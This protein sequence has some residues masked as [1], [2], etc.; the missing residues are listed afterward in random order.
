[1]AD[2]S[3]SAPRNGVV[4]PQNKQTYAELHQIADHFIGGNRVENAKDSKVKDFVIAN[5]GH[6][7]ITNVLI[8]NNGIA[9][10]KEI[11]SVRKW[12]YETFG[13]E[14]AI[15]FTV[16]AT[17][18]DLQANADYIRMADH[19]VEVPGGT[20]NHNYANVELIVDIAER[21]NVHAVWAGWGHASENPK[22]PESLAASP[23]KI[24][25]IGPPGSAMRSLGDKISSTI[26]A[27]H[28][29]VPCIPWSGT[30]VDEV[31]V[32]DNGIVT[33]ADDVYMKGCV[34]SWQEGLEKAR[35]IGFPVMIKASE[36]GGGKGIR[37]AMSED[38]FE[39]LYKAAASEIPG[40]PIFIM[41][42]ASSA[43]HLEV[44][45]LADQYGN[46]ISLF[47]RD[48]SVQRRHQ[49]IIEE[50]P[51]TIA[52]APTF[53]AMED[54]AVR[55]GRL[56]GYVSAGT[57]EY[58]Y[59]HHD[60]KFYF[61]ELNP[62][63]QVEHPTTEMVSGV[64]LP[65]AQLQIAMGLPLHR[66]RDIRLL[67]GVDPKAATEI[68]FEF[69]NEGSAK[70][71]RRPTPKGHTTA[72]RIT[73]E[74]PGEGFKPSNGVMHD[75]NFRS[76][77]NVWGYFS[78]STGSG[79]HSFS[80]SQFGH[81]FAY[82]ENRQASRKH[83]VV[84]LKELSIRGDFRTTVEYL[85]KLLETEAF[86]ENTITTGWLDELISNKL[87]AERPDSTLA[88]VCGAVTKAHI[89]S[90]QCFAD[91][92]AGLNKGQ[93][94]SKDIL[95]TVF[96]V[97]FIY[98]GYRYKFTVTRSS[99][100][101]YHLFINGSKCSVGVRALSDGGL[102]IL[103]DGRS[104]SI[105][106][107]EEVGAT[108]V[109]V[110]SKTCLLE[111]END[112]TQLRSPSPGKLVSYS[113]ENGEHVAAGQIFA[114]VEVMKMYMPLVAQEDGVVQLIK[115]PGATLEAGD[116]LGILVLDDPSRVKQAQPFLGHLPEFGPPMIAGDKP[117][118]RFSKLHE[119][120]TNI[121]EGFDNT[122]VMQSTLKELVEVLRN[123]ELP[124]SEWNA[125]FSALHSRMPQKLDAQFAQLVERAKQRNAEFPAKALARAFQKF[126]DDNVAPNDANT[127]RTTLEPLTTILEL[128]S[129]GQ[130]ARELKVIAD[131]LERYAE[132]ERLFSGKK[133][134]DE[135]IILAL[136]DENKEDVSKVV[137]TV[138][139]HSRVTAKNNLILAILDVYRPN[140]P[141][142]GNIAKYLRPVLRI[143]A[144]LESR[145]TAK[146]SLKAREIL[147]QC[148]LPSLE[149]RKAQMEHI[150]RSSVVESKYGE[151]GLDHRNP[152][153][154]VIKEVVDSKYT[155]FDVLPQFFAHEDPWVGLAA[156]EV[157]V[158]RAYRA[159][160]I[161]QIEYHSDEA[162]NPSFVSWDFVLRKMGQSELGLP[163]ESAAP[164]SPATPATPGRADYGFGRINSISDMSYLTRKVGEDAG[165]RG[166]I[167]PCKYMDDVEDLLAKA[168]EILPLS[169]KGQ[170][171]KNSLIP[172]LAGKRKPA[173]VR[174]D[175]QDEL[176]NVVNIAVR[177]SES[178]NDA[179]NLAR[180][181]DIIEGFKGELNA[182]GVRRVTFI[183]GRADGSYPAYY[184]FRGPT[185][186]ED[187][188]IRHN[189]P[190]LAFQLEL[191]R[192]SKFR[193]KPVFTENKNIHVYEAVAKENEADKRYFTRAVI[194]PGRLRDEIPTAEYLISEADRVINDIFDALE[195]IGNNNSDLNHL[196]INFTPVFQLHPREVEYS[197][198]GFLDRFG[199]RGWR[200]RVAQVEIRIICTDP[201]TG[202]P[203]P[204]RVVIT[205]TSGFVVQVEVY[206]E[207]KSEKGE[208]VFNSLGGTTKI[209]AM[210]LLP[211]STPY[212]T[213]NQLQPKRYKAHL[214]GTQYVYDFPEL[215]RQA[216]Q[217]SWAEAVKVTPSLAEKQPPVG[218][219]IDYSEL[220]L[221]DTDKLA[222]V[223]REPGTNTHGM[224]GW[225]I[226][227]RTPEYPRGRRFVLISNDITYQIGSFGPKEDHYF[228]KC[229]ELARKL[230]VPRIYLS[231]N[232]GA[233]LGV[234]NELMS[235]FKVAFNDPNKQEAGFKYL[236]LDDEAKK[237][238]E[239]SVITEEIVE[240]GEKRH[241]IT[242]IV[243]KEDG[244]GVE[245]LRGS[246]LIAGATSRAYNDIFTCTL[247][248]CRSVGIGA[249][250]VRLGQRAVQ[251]E[252]QPIILTGAP[253]LNNLLGREV[254]T[255]NL[256]L[257]GTQIMYR[258]GVSHM[259]AEDDMA[260]ISKIVQWMSY[261]PDKR[262]N[263][264][265][266]SPSADPWDRDVVFTPVPR[267]PYDVRWMIAGKQ[268]GDDFQ[269]GLFDKDSFVETLGGW[270][271][272][273]VVGRARLSGIPMG[274][275][276]VETRSIEN[277]TPADPANPDSIE[278]VSQEAGG[279]WYPNSA[280]KTAQAIND[281][282]YGEQLP[283][284]ILA[285][286][287]G[288]S[289]GQRDM[290]NEVLKY[291][292]FIVD[293]L[294]K[295]EQPIFVYIPPHGELRG[296]S[297]VVVD[298]TINPVAM[299]MYADVEARG[300]VLE[301]EGIVGIK[302]RKDKQLQNM[303]R[304]DAVY[305]S[306]KKKLAEAQ[307]NNA[308]KD[309]IE[310]IHKEITAREELILPVYTQISLQFADLHDRSGRMKA[311]GVIREQLEWV[312]S[313]R[314][315]YWRVRR[316][317]NEEY[318]LRRMAAATS[319]AG[320]VTKDPVALRNHHLAK[321]QAWSGVPEFDTKDREVAVWYEEHRQQVNDKVAALK[322]E[323]T[324]AHIAELLVDKTAFEGVR[325]ALSNL[326]IAEKEA[327]LK[328]LSS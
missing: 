10:V 245:C 63:L 62:R 304:N 7:V 139:S 165:R 118:Q 105:Y 156:L 147:I 281:F 291:G 115:Q 231:A 72:C 315:F 221:D 73:S 138:L 193:I 171:K 136:R 151:S 121:L 49:K 261:V 310:S 26:V 205:N 195:I 242:T 44:Q 191:N 123:P 128:Y 169:H 15:Q 292:S 271:R 86:E 225:L 34:Q 183:C 249:Y 108:R 273:V 243:G 175:S 116:I 302:F 262:N 149:E 87:T 78:V 146:V 104:H 188:S 283:L 206:A 303:A 134:Q 54:A 94:P 246:G 284:M 240:D 65:A 2:A 31:T 289:G 25:F 213:K 250:L 208:W 120:L 185:Y 148:A 324:Q 137:T 84:A 325:A 153:L 122:V 126:L 109:S 155:V 287:R 238:F 266:I 133:Q 81:I 264:V 22:L 328:Q 110:D 3:S 232:S 4:V 217:N 211:V 257:G 179:D 39:Q 207:R 219:C 233:R 98:E 124:Y 177:D 132:V 93:V 294:V 256:Q 150:L 50:A 216:I 269:P 318:I 119:T 43:R 6:T 288:F 29:A 223:S 293:A 323:A 106:W 101:S 241:K 319:S 131:I 67:Y 236:Y 1:M 168:L 41:K 83:M 255:S 127:L 282:N 215:F 125:Q 85:I 209:G 194:R 80:D 5:S 317:L 135:E 174:R 117:A 91:Y 114:E 20:N 56:V 162:E 32:D 74:D 316:R 184:T 35:Q 60:D 42:L 312:N 24:V 186:E 268:E 47:G 251:V 160:V 244:L 111:Q 311:K 45:L 170:A 96:P 33:V 112:P 55:L 13:D 21:M 263:P 103:L 37:K 76:S 247:V 254:Y 277:V 144:D 212:P 88:V 326:P 198:Q 52:K 222:E 199:P 258:N 200:L 228:N 285:N 274:V 53:R 140:K 59:S 145:Q 237:R 218:D 8:A 16:M 38:G 51:V 23:K 157:Y 296:G 176:S 259:T 299:E 227:A 278:Q 180:I 14:R 214:M 260:G 172:D 309:E 102:L 107:K 129:E 290:Y 301:P 40:S 307:A 295:Y 12:A 57:V 201:A 166:V 141:N 181:T 66:I 275:I 182:R 210:H 48:C 152:A 197:L 306:L 17:P 321:L 130:K 202:T 142:V 167:V 68:D 163:I 300:G 30:G 159:Y 18:E 90:E 224:V 190:A 77:S 196:F 19:Y 192:L 69:K 308:G 327:L 36:G 64:N 164:S 252:G 158:R 71:Q 28:A 187:D 239:G 178:G 320:A 143:L 92:K 298:P 97:D 279:V 322:V 265:P 173:P 226:N 79:I 234:A 253:A 203:Y 161:K 58:L 11:R 276:A 154:D 99:M 286:W 230:G 314:F 297:W 267:Q 70:T 46:N 313:R 280:F 61:L 270:A 220:V 113:V 95:K 82:G 229:T 235:H 305:A 204:L 189:E 9:A 27:Q 248:T 75:L 89:A 100:D 272:T